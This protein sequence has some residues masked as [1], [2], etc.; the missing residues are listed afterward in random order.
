[1]TDRRAQ[2]TRQVVALQA[3]IAA[4]DEEAAR[5]DRPITDRILDAIER[6][7]PRYYITLGLEG[8]ED[9]DF[10]A[11]G[12]VNQYGLRRFA[13]GGVTATLFEAAPEDGWE[14]RGDYFAH[15]PDYADFN[16]PAEPYEYDD[17]CRMAINSNQGDPR[18]WTLLLGMLEM[19]IKQ[20]EA[21]KRP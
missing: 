1:M 4:I 3:E 18:F 14:T 10:E 11:V 13:S 9:E 21:K 2:L 8:A 6:L 19:A 16:D 5:Q 7:P 12:E 17:A 15:T 20:A